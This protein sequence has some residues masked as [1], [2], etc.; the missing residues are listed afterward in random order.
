M[1]R[2]DF[3]RRAAR[4]ALAVPIAASLNGPGWAEAA[5]PA[6]A[7]GAA[8]RTAVPTHA[9]PKVTINAKD[10]TFPPELG[11]ADLGVNV[12]VADWSPVNLTPEAL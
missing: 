5:K 4:S 10:L 11:A 3:L 8:P 1:K 9:G 7:Q 2:R 6:K 12:T